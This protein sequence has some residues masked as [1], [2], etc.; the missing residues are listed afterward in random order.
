MP[1]VTLLEKVYGLFSAETFEPV[2]SSLCRGLRVKL[3][4]AGTTDR[5][6]I[7]VELFGDDETA[8]MNYLNRE[9]GLAPVSVEGLE[10]FSTVRG[11]VVSF[12]ESE[13]HLRVDVGVFSP[14]ICDAVVSLQSLRAQLADGKEFSLRQ[15]AELFCFCDNL[16]LTV[17]VVGGVGA[18]ANC[19]EAELSEFQ[20][21]QVRG[22]IRSGLDRLLVL[23]ALFSDV[24][25]AVYASKHARDVVKLESLGLLEHVVVCKLGTNAVGLVPRFGRFLPRAALA[26]FRPRKI[27]ELVGKEFLF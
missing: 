19:V 6:W 12:G 4:V 2:F 22:W 17:K 26:P 3:K 20:L 15:M 23:G 10:K 5:G 27:W 8:A 21:S 24:E 7:Q 18:E 11:R 13:D 25:R 9:V 1:I 14:R 16:P